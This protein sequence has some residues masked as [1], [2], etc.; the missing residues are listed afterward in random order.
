MGGLAGVLLGKEISQIQTRIHGPQR[1]KQYLECIRPFMDA[2]FG[3]T[4]YPTAVEEL[5]YENEFYEDP[6]LKVQYIPLFGIST[7]SQQLVDVAYLIELKVCKGRF[8]L[9]RGE[10]G[11]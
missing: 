1:I 7:S 8:I 2:D 6:A 5:S 9:V 10:K 4:S 3:K 11:V